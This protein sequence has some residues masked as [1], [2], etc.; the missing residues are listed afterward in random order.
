MIFGIICFIVS[1]FGIIGYYNESFTITYIAFVLCLLE[2]IF[3]KITGESKTMQF[4]IIS[5][6]IGWIATENFKLGI[7]IG[8][9]F[10]NVI[11]FIG[12]IIM[13]LLFSSNKSNA[14]DKN[15]DIDSTI[16]I[17]EKTVEKAKKDLKTGIKRDELDELL[18]N[19]YITQKTYNEV[20]NNIESLE[21]IANLDVDELKK[22]LQK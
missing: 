3:G 14:K 13:I 22:N 17:A 12:G 9:C 2:N 21:A 15:I 10:E 5:C 20:L 7:T 11:A 16:R 19:N 4:F 1:I 8:A 6:I 18:K